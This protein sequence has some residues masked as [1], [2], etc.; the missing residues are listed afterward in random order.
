MKTK[1]RNFALLHLLVFSYSLTG[2]FSKL[3]SKCDFL[4]L[5]FILFYSVVLVILFIYAISWQQILKMMPLTT[6]FLNKAVVV[7]WGLIWGSII[8][9][10]KVT[11][12]MI[13]G[14]VIII[15]GVFMVVSGDE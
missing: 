4:S 10:E 3:A 2:I 11:W 5:K 15:L 7:I 9:H 12:N 8:F 13:L 14:S 6:A 1:I